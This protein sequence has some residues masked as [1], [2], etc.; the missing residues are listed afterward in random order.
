MRCPH[1]LADDMRCSACISESWKT[2]QGAVLTARQ[3][4]PEHTIPALLI[5]LNTDTGELDVVSPGWIKDTQDLKGLLNSLI[6]R[7]VM[8]RDRLK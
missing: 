2:F 5:C 6:D 1:G 7:V 4:L 3:Q 8:R